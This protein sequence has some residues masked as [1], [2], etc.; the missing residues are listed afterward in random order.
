MTN[1]FAPPPVISLDSG[2]PSRALTPSK[3]TTGS[4]DASARSAGAARKS[5]PSGFRSPAVPRS[6]NTGISTGSPEPARARSAAIRSSAAAA[7]WRRA[8]SSGC[9]SSECRASRRKR[10]K[11]APTIRVIPSA[12][13][14]SVTVKPAAAGDSPRLGGRGVS[15]EPGERRGRVRR[16]RRP[17]AKRVTGS[18]PPLTAARTAIGESP[19]RRWSRPRGRPPAPGT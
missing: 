10:V 17:A 7:S 13:S 2:T 16:N 11:P 4:K 18:L 15:T 19:R 5:S 8:A 1:G 12:T 6:V 3:P 9:R 14:A